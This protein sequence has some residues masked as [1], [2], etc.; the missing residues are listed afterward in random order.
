VSGDAQHAAPGAPLPELLTVELRDDA[1][2]PIA[3]ASVTWSATGGTITPSA[4]VTDQAGRAAARWELGAV[5]GRYTA[6]ATTTHAAPARFTALA[7]RPAA[8]SLLA[9]RLDTYD[10]SGQAVHPDHVALPASWSLGSQALAVTPYPNGDAHFE[11]PSLYA[12]DDGDLW[13]VPEGLVNP[14]VQPREGYLSD[15]DALYDP[16]TGELWVYYRQVTT[17]NT[18]WLIR[19]SD[20]VHWSTPVRVAA[21]PNHEIISPAI[22]RR[23]PGDWRMWAVNAG[24]AGCAGGST[25]VELRQSAD[26]VHWS[27]PQPVSLDQPGGFPWHLDVTWIPSRNEFWALYPTKTRGNCTTTALHFATSADGVH[28][29]TYPAPLLAHGALPEFADVVYRSTLEYDAA[30]GSVDVWYSGAR[31]DGRAYVWHLA[32]ERLLLAALLDRVFGRTTTVAANGLATRATDAP[33]LTNATA[34]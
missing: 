16:D 17:V 30:S 5:P 14:L 23:G 2:R 27:A 21:A 8:N 25:T 33:P 12:G 10:G 29:R 4:P 1:G 11:N 26:G 19:S 9:L 32:H 22:V 20:G 3:A 18:I 31:F 13:T 15:P 7:V 28:W 6:A 34:P 24:G